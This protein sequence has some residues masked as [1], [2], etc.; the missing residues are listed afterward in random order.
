MKKFIKKNYILIL[1]TLIGFI[2]RIAGISQNP[3]SLNWDEASHGYNAYSILK[4]SRDEWGTFLPTIFP[5][6]GDYKLPLYIYLTVP[7]VA[8]FGLNV[9]SVRLVSV[10]AGTLAIPAI[11]LLTNKLFA[12]KKLLILNHQLSIGEIAGATLALLP[13]HIFI[14]RPAL[15]AN[16]AL[17]F[18]VAG[19]YFLLKKSF[20]PASIFFSLSLHTYN[21]ARLFIPLILIFWF[22]IYRPK[23]KINK[24]NIISL[25][26]IFI[27]G[28]IVLYQIF[29]GAGTARYS[30]ISLLSEH[31]VYVIGENRT[32]SNLPGILPRLV[33]NRPVQ[34]SKMVIS[35]YL[36]HFT[37]SFIYQSDG[38]NNQFSIPNT[39]MITW[40]IIVA[41]FL[42]LFFTLKNIK[43]KNSLFLLALL[44]LS[45]LADSLTIDPA[46]ALRS[47]IMIP[48]LVIISAFGFFHTSLKTKFKNIL[49]LLFAITLIFSTV[50]YWK[51]YNTEYKNNYSQSWQYGY[52]QAI[53]YLNENKDKYSRIIISKRY[54]EPHI[55]YAF[56]T[57][58]NSQNLWSS[59]DNIRF[60]QTNW[61]WTDK[62]GKVF[63]INDW[64]IPQNLPSEVL[65]LESG[66]EV[67][68]RN[69]LLITSPDHVPS[70]AEILK[71]INFLDGSPAF[72]I[73][74]FN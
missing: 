18:I 9:F 21:T 55:F 56:Y 66:S 29:T 25:I 7:F 32:N 52:Q 20:I 40:P 3:P 42:G 30:Q 58:L 10:L 26:I 71:E 50:N 46:H 65:V 35:K 69:S 67:E 2:I 1:I 74:K 47:S 15:E 62:V 43:Q 44:F 64:L 5:A 49:L 39:N 57:N 24:E 72:V 60:T 4:T 19:L 63:F 17:T 70:N 68:T 53:S 16:L 41:Y 48:A 38:A 61:R 12:N 33:Y 13:W 27:A 73:A 59:G 23:L 28:I 8:L 51:K 22:L 11:C 31:Q 45:P 37:P 54:A 14:S 6:F 34:V 36:E